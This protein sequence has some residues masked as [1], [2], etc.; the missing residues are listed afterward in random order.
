[1]VDR[2]AACSA[3]QTLTPG[4]LVTGNTSTGTSVVQGC[5]LAWLVGDA[6]PENVW[7]LTVPQA[8]GLTV[9]VSSTWD[10]S[11]YILGGPGSTCANAPLLRADACADAVVSNA[12]EV[13]S[14]NQVEAGTYWVV[15]DGYRGGFTT[16]TSGSY[17]L[18][19]DLVPGGQCVVDP[20]ITPPA[21]NNTAG[22][23]AF[24][25]STPSP[26]AVC[27]GDEDWYRFSVGGGDASVVLTPQGNTPGSLLVDFYTLTTAGTA[28]TAAPYTTGVVAS[29]NT[30]RL[31]NP[32][33]GAY[34]VRVRGTGL[35]QAGVSYVIALRDACFLDPQEPDDSLAAA[36]IVMNPLGGLASNAGQ[37]SCPGNADVFLVPAPTNGPATI[38]VLGGAAVDLR[39]QG[40]TLGTNDAVVDN[41]AGVTQSTVGA[42][43]VVQWNALAGR[44][45]AF[46]VTR[47]AGSIT[48]AAYAVR[49]E[50][51]PANN[52]VC[53]SAVALTLPA[54]NEAIWVPFTTVGRADNLATVDIFCDLGSLVLSG[55]DV[56]FTF[57]TAGTMPKLSFAILTANGSASVNHAVY[58]LAG[59]CSGTEVACQLNGFSTDP[60]TGAQYTLVVDGALTGGEMVLEVFRLP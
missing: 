48:G 53:S 19:A 41:P 12:E 5:Q 10:A 52:D 55:P 6:A 46:T 51:A 15:V 50:F 54:V 30:Y 38:T 21:S 7:V 1:M 56:F 13:I 60:L 58:M 44:V 35:G 27:S 25:S 47:P 26:E 24:L 18:R 45:L 49:T 11:V 43:R 40:V 2:T 33:A 31:V 34:G 23:A 20:S 42:D 3:A 8:G 4:T 59:G 22:G 28:V 32:P 17:T 39:V 14:L 9:R 29:G 57:A 36:P 37:S 16:P